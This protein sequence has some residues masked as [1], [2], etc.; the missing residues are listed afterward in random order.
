[1]PPVSTCFVLICVSHLLSFFLAYTAVA[2]SENRKCF[3]KSPEFF[4]L[5]I[6][7]FVPTYIKPKLNRDVRRSF[8]L[9]NMPETRPSASGTNSA[10]LYGLAC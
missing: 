3:V 5:I 2:Y 10:I 1:M 4:I 8:F 9:P 7:L 6:S